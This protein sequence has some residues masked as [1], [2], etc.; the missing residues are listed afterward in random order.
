MN[1]AS[2]RR[3]TTLFAALL[4]TSHCAILYAQESEPLGPPIDDEIGLISVDQLPP[5]EVD[6]DDEELAAIIAEESAPTS[7]QTDLEELRDS[8]DLYKT[9]LENFSYDEADTLAK[10]MVELSIRLYGLDSHE[11]SNALT[12]LGLVQHKNKEY[13]SA[14]LNFTAAVE[15]IERIEDRLSGDLIAPLQGLGAAQLGAGRPDLAR[16]TYSRA[17]HTSH[18]NE[19]PHNLMQIEMLES[20]AETYLTLGD[21]KKAVKLHEHI[22]NL[23][24]RNTDLESEEIIPALE[25]QAEWLHRMSM[26]DRERMTWRRIIDILEDTRGKDDL[27]L[28]DPLTGLAKSYLFVSEFTFDSYSETASML[29]GDTYLKRADRI[30]TE[31]PDATWRLRQQTLMSLG[32]YYVLSLR[33]TKAK[34]VYSVAWELLSED[35]EKLEMRKRLLEEP[36]VLQRVFPPKYYNSESGGGSPDELRTGTIVLKYRITDRGATRDI[37]VIDARPAGLDDMEYSV[38]RELRRLVHRPRMYE[39]EFVD[40]INQTYVHEFYYQPSDLPTAKEEQT[41]ETVAQDES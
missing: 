30:A 16:G 23:E 6:D 24:A 19:G 7:R 31:N 32:D 40:T 33:S 12:N 15:I 36:Q 17:V 37:E 28:I 13:E 26:F 39:G 35:E 21:R 11:S 4:G 8:F 14:V 9:A 10:R 3:I 18:V 27:S 29:S 25:R 2:S 5:A 20:L 1:D 41:E 34:R 38:E 22:Y